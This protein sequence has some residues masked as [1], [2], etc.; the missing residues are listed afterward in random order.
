MDDFLLDILGDDGRCCKL[1]E[2]FYSGMK[3]DFVFSVVKANPGINQY[4]AG[5]KFC[6]KHKKFVF[7]YECCMEFKENKCS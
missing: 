4:R 2:H 7:F 5:H 1:C 3:R 6:L